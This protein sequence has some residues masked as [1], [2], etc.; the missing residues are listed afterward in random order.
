MVARDKALNNR[1]RGFEVRGIGC[2]IH[3][4]FTA[5]GKPDMVAVT[6]VIFHITQGNIFFEFFRNKLLK[7][8]LIRLCSRCWPARLTC[9]GGPYHEKGFNAQ[10]GSSFDKVIQGRD[11]SFRAF[12]RKP[13]LSDKP[14][15]DEIL[16][17]NSFYQMTRYGLFSLPEK[18]QLCSWSIPCRCLQP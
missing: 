16:E 7:N 5:I 3:A 10:C 13:F 17:T 9:P 8:V 2:H 18:S 12:E 15:V 6:Q 14:A 1:G 11:K 4:D